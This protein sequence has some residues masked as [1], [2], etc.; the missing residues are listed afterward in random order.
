MRRGDSEHVRRATLVSQIVE[1]LK[2][3]H[4]ESFVVTSPRK[5]LSHSCQT[6][7]EYNHIV[8]NSQDNEP[9]FE[10][11]SYER[12]SGGG[13]DDVDIYLP[14]PPQGYRNRKHFKMS[15]IVVMFTQK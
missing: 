12:C 11:S 14:T 10:R 8:M 7:G 6:W 1:E 4:V 15:D 3:L 2:A 13:Y 9:R 5:Q